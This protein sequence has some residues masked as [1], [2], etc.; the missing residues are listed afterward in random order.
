MFCHSIEQKL[1]QH[2]DFDR[3]ISQD[4]LFVITLKLQKKITG[5]KCTYFYGLFTIGYFLETLLNVQPTSSVMGIFSYI[6]KN[7]WRN[8]H[9]ILI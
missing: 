4:F 6:D 1:R 7:L 5:S 9:I 3:V 2:K 8:T